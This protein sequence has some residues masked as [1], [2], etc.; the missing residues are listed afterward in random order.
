MLHVQYLQ[1]AAA[2][3]GKYWL[4]LN[5]YHV[6]SKATIKGI[7]DRMLKGASTDDIFAFKATTSCGMFC[8]LG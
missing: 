3:K 1:F 8:R 6:L 4:C 7:Q 2:G 5:C